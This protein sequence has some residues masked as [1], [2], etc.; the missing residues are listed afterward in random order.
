MG[1]LHAQQKGKQNASAVPY[2]QT[3]QLV[4]KKFAGLANVA[5]GTKLQHRSFNYTER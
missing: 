4:L 3:E 1:A 5:L 2:L